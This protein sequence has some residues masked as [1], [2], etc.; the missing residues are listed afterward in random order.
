VGPFDLPELATSEPVTLS[1][2]PLTYQLPS[3]PEKEI[4]V[5]VRLSIV[6]VTVGSSPTTVFF[7]RSTIMPMFITSED[8]RAPPLEVSVP[9]HASV[10]VVS[11]ACALS[12]PQV[13]IAMRAMTRE[14]VRSMEKPDQSNPCNNVPHSWGADYPRR[15]LLAN[16]AIAASRV[17]A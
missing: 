3:A 15:Q 4:V 11:A 13:T 12:N 5:S 7:W 8:V 2:M 10:S 14:H 17:A 16:A 1:R 9:L 6:R